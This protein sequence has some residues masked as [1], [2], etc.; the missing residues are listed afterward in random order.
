MLEQLLLLFYI[1]YLFVDIDIFFVDRVRRVVRGAFYK[2]IIDFDKKNM[3]D[4]IALA[5]KGIRSNLQAQ[6][7]ALKGI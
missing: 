3:E 1:L 6:N 4:L 2:K 7:Y 5:E